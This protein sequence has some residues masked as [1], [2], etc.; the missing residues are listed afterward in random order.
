MGWQ[1]PAAFPGT[2][3]G[4]SLA[5]S[6]GAVGLDED[7]RVHAIGLTLPLAPGE[8]I[9]ARAT[10]DA[11][12]GV[13]STEVLDAGGEVLLALARGRSPTGWTC[14]VRGSGGAAGVVSCAHGAASVALASGTW[15][16]LRDGGLEWLVGGPLP[17]RTGSWGHAEAIDVQIAPV[18]ADVV[19]FP[20]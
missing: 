3:F 11:S 7:L 15:A 20:W 13:A 9:V 19:D 2:H 14:A 6:V 1:D 8:A 12:A 5:G 17:A 10:V 4:V 16:T 18:R